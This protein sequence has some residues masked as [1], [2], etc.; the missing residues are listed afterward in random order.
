LIKGVWYAA[1]KFQGRFIGKKMQEKFC[2]V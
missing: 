1:F 2:L